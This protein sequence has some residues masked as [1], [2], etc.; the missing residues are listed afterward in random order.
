MIMGAC[1]TIIVNYDTTSMPIARPIARTPIRSPS[2]RPVARSVPWIKPWVIERIIE[3]WII[4]WI[5]VPWG[6]EA[7]PCPVWTIEIIEATQVNGDGVVIIIAIART[8]VCLGVG[9]NGIVY[10]CD[11]ACRVGVN[12]IAGSEFYDVIAGGVIS[13]III[14]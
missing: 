7:I 1:A 10:H 11:N 14:M 3:P 5:V 8:L 12:A 6:V 4:E 13:D 9:C 2:S